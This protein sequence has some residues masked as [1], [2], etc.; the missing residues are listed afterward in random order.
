MDKV[1]LGALCRNQF[2][3]WPALL[4]AG[5]RADRRGLDSLWT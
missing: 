5:S 4:K 3:D 1:R 2:P